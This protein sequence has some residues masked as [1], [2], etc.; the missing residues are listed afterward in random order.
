MTEDEAKTKWCPMFRVSNAGAGGSQY[1]TTSFETKTNR[2]FI[3]QPQCLASG[4]M[5]YR[6]ELDAVGMLGDGQV[7]VADM[8][9]NDLIKEGGWWW[10]GRYVK[11]GN[12]YLHR[13]IAI[14][15]YGYLPEGMFVDHIDGDPLNLRRGNLRVVTPQ[16]NAANAAPR[17]GASQYRGVYKA[18]SGRWAAQIAKEGIRQSLGT[19][20]TEQEA[21]AA[22]DAAA[23]EMHGEYARLN[24][25]PKQNQG[26][27]GFCGLAGRP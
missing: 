11:T 7:F 21:A 19:Y 15:E 17:G 4:C 23:K 20:D 3:S 1:S 13:I 5:A 27:H 25:E 24:L 18:R 10:D 9:D 26:R 14:R 6:W 16:Q 22:Y 8:V 2:N 12:G